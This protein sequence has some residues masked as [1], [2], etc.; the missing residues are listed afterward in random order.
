MSLFK[1]NPGTRD[2]VTNP[3]PSFVGDGDDQADQ[4]Y[5]VD[6]VKKMPDNRRHKSRSIRTVMYNPD[7]QNSF[8]R[9]LSGR[10]L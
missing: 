2:K 4:K 7:T 10:T 9:R 1:Y 6:N 3:F 8:S 5:T